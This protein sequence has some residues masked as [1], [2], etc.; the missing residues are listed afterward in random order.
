MTPSPIPSTDAAV[1]D[2][3]S[4]SVRLVIYRLEGRAIWTIYNEKVLAG[5]G[6]DL[7][8]TGKLSPP[9]CAA[10][11]AALRRFK[12]VLDAVR[13]DAIYTAATAAVREASDGED[14]VRSVLR[15]TGLDLRI[16][17]GE[18]EARY[19]ALGVVAGAPDAGGV[20]GDLGGYSLELVRIK[21]GGPQDRVTL[22]LGPFAL[23]ADWNLDEARRVVRKVLTPMADRFRGGCFYAVGGA[24]RNLA[25]VQMQLTRYPLEILHQYEIAAREALETTAFISRQSKGSLE[26]LPRVSKKRAESLPHA[27]VVLEGIIEHLGVETIQISAFGLRE[28]LLLDSMTQETRARDPL[29]AGCAALGARQDI[30]EDLGG[31]LEA[32]L[33]PAFATL[34]AIFEQGRDR[35]LV[36]AAC[37]LAELGSRLH[38]DHRAQLVFEQVLRAPVAGVSH[39]ERAFL[40]C[41]VYARHTA[42]SSIPETGIID[43]LLDKDGITRARALGAGIRLGCDL[44]GRSSVLLGR[45]DLDI[46]AA[47]V[48]LT[49]GKADADLLLGEQTARRAQTLASVLD[50]QLTIET[51]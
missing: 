38:P 14:F 13:P 2:V 8:R 36:A 48:H 42:S 23:G 9:G 31:A 26:R 7:K 35:V 34:P 10:A 29:V 27:A 5:L 50:R 15:E 46:D 33:S 25:L 11:L 39:R 19:S 1:I 41:A 22:P 24:W 51:R 40:A 45:S 47:A 20:A 37:R 49:A 18:D 21:D 6:R 3:G 12:A 17:S 16:I 44:S 32:W 28:G 43:R 4:N 30:A